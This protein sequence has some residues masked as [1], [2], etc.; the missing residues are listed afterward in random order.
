MDTTAGWRRHDYKR[1]CDICG[2]PW[3][4]S[5]LRPIGEGRLACPDDYQ[6]LTAEQISR[7]NSSVPPL[8]VK[9][10]KN[11]RLQTQTGVYQLDEA[12]LFDA[13]CR[14]GLGAPLASVAGPTGALVTARTMGSVG[15]FGKYLGDLIA[16]GTRPTS[17]LNRA[18]TLLRSA[19]DT[20]LSNQR[21]FSPTDLRWGSFRD[22]NGLDSVVETAAA[23]LCLVSAFVILGDTKYRDA[24]GYAATF[25]RH[26]QRCD[27]LSSAFTTNAAGARLYTG[28]WPATVNE[29]TKVISNSFGGASVVALWFLGE[30]RAV[31]GG[32]TTYGEAAFGADFVASTLGTLDQMIADARAFYFTGS[33]ADSADGTVK[34]L[35]KMP[36]LALYT[37][38]VSGNGGT[39]AFTRLAGNTVNGRD[40]AM[41]TRALMAIEGYTAT[42]AALYTYLLSFTS[43]P[44]FQ[45][46][47]GASPKTVASSTTGNY[48]PT[49]AL[50]TALSV[51]TSSA[52]L[53]Q[54]G[55]SIYDLATAG[56]LADVRVAS[57]SDL[58]SLKEQL[59]RPR[60][61]YA[62]HTPRD[63][64]A[65][66]LGPI[67]QCGL[68]FQVSATNLDLVAASQ[69]GMAYR[70]APG[71]DS[72]VR[73]PS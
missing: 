15:W 29:T 59:A 6:G 39:G 16:Q 57:G 23:G 68:S 27:L 4:R 67:G 8:T 31:V 63:D 19:A 43:N 72:N 7:Y 26:M 13:V 11:V 42:T 53:T 48:D 20:L 54:N 1:V 66:P 71:A 49:F 61:Q 40:M 38:F 37:A 64:K 56:L 10:H 55:S 21:T 36:P 28:G 73:A 9:P 70:F 35:F 62:E 45:T 34:P 41:A 14:F 25:M 58:L 12:L 52:P 51:G 44:S 69:L 47:A 18:T 24:A 22:A 2:H 50:T 32:G 3:M 46:A 17:W 5:Q 60:R 33:V 65:W 30:L